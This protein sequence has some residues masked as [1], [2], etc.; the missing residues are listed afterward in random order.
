MGATADRGMPP[1]PPL[2]ALLAP[3]ECAESRV[4]CVRGSRAERTGRGG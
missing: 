1:L 2:L 3:L 4:P